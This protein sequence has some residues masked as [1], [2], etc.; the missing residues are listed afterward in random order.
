MSLRGP[1][2]QRK[3][4]MRVV[5]QSHGFKLKDVRTIFTDNS[6]AVYEFIWDTPNSD[7]MIGQIMG[8]EKHIGEFK[9]LPVMTSLKS[10]II[11]S[12]TGP[13]SI[14]YRYRHIAD[15]EVVP[16]GE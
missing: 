11:A 8:L 9:F 3:Q 1:L 16:A 5:L 7:P 6:I 14:S 4:Y 15:V 10:S 13:K 2:Y 12:K